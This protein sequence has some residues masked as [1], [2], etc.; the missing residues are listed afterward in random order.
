[1]LLVGS[2]TGSSLDSG[3]VQ[4]E[5]EQEAAVDGNRRGGGGTAK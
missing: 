3:S 2:H 1:V 5:A 4:Q